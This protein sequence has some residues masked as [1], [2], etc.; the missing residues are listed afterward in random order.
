MPA[1]FVPVM[2][3]VISVM[4]HQIGF[5]GRSGKTPDADCYGGES[6]C[7]TRA[8]VDLVEEN[9]YRLQSCARRS[10]AWARPL[11]EKVSVVSVPLAD[12]PLTTASADL[13]IASTI[14]SSSAAFLIQ[15]PS[16]WVYIA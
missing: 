8:P 5:S 1:E 9:G 3:S 10:S 15:R 6:A 7:L 14:R 4:G 11:S 16:P 13:R 12:T 2:V